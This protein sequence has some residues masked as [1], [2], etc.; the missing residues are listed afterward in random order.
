MKAKVSRKPIKRKSPTTAQMVWRIPKWLLGFEQRVNAK[1][2]SV[3]RHLDILGRDVSV[4]LHSS[5]E[6][7]EDNLATLPA[8]REA[9]QDCTQLMHLYQTHF[10][11]LSC[12]LGLTGSQG[13]TGAVGPICSAGTHSAPDRDVRV[14]PLRCADTRKP[15]NPA[16]TPYNANQFMATPAQD[17]PKGSTCPLCRIN[18]DN[19]VYCAEGG[20]EFVC[21]AGKGRRGTEWARG[22]VDT[23]RP[24]ADE[25]DK[26]RA[27]RDPALYATCS[28][29]HLHQPG[30]KCAVCC[31]T[32]G[33]TWAS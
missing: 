4:F 25:L 3:E 28:V 19:V 13:Q 14:E 30:I 27:L 2:A 12:R 18:L 7:R 5:K 26:W 21:P 29:A 31:V 32:P 17:P 8:I 22:R 23:R 1:L 6:A 9:I 11:E 24:E 33:L 20:G 15:D 16:A 10:E